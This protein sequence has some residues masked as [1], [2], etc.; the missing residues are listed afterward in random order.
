[1]V[2]RARSQGWRLI[3][4]AAA[5]ARASASN[6][7]TVC[8]ARMLERP[9]CLSDCFSSSVAGALALRQVGLHA[10]ARQRRLELV[11]GV[12]QKALLRGQ[13]SLSAGSAGR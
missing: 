6:W 10:Q 5:S 7:L 1:M 4:R 9:I 3:C 11:C 13:W 2:R 12:G 8:V